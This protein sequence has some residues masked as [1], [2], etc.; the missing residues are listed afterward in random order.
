MRRLSPLISAVALV[1][2][3]YALAVGC[4]GANDKP[5]LV[6]SWGKDGVVQLPGFEVKQTIEDS[7]GR[8]VAVGNYKGNYAE[9]VRLLANGSL[10]S[11]FGKDG[12]VRWPFHMFQGRF[13][14][15]MDYLGWDLVTLLPDGRIVLAGTNMVGNVDDKTTLVVSELDESGK[16]VG[17]FGDNGYFTADKRLYDCSAASVAKGGNACDRQF[18]GLARK[19]TTCT[20]GPAGLAIQGEK[21]VVSANRFCND[22][23]PILHIVVMR[24]NAN[25]TRDRSFGK[26]GEVTVSGTAPL[27]VSAPLIVLPNDHL[28]V[29]GTT[30]KGEKVQLTELLPN[31]AIDRIF[32]QKGVVFTKAAGGTPGNLTGLMSDKQGI[33]SLTGNNFTGESGGPFV[34]RFTGQGHPLDF[35]TGS[36]LSP[37]IRVKGN[38]ENFG[39]KTFGF[40]AA[41][42]AQLP[43]GE[44]VGAGNLLARITS[45]GALDTSYPPLELYGGGKLITGGMFGGILA[46]SDGT[47]LVTLLKQNP[48]ETLTANLARYR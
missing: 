26:K 21:I 34:V 12:V 29:G 36:R 32:G 18:F 15:G 31:G 19:K 23:D 47:V 43:N 10:D 46:A 27:V 11:S 20:R 39:A 35:R 14:N 9:V 8:I 45:E 44:L 25:G 37:S 41:I 24:L 6:T 2:V 42:F 3:L 48:S 30:P 38:Y 4:G 16:V 22:A 7:S 13:P 33:L 17:S 5:G 1:L 28:V 40:A